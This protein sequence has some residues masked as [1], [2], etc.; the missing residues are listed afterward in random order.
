MY[1]YGVKS[2][3]LWVLREPRYVKDLD[4]KSNPCFFADP[5]TP[6]GPYQQKVLSY[7]SK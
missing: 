5:W 7:D 2:P 1:I 4:K 3:F 6:N